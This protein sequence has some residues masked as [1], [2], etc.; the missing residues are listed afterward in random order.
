LFFELGP[1]F[2]R[3]IIWFHGSVSVDWNGIGYG[4]LS[5]WCNDWCFYNYFC[6]LFWNCDWCNLDNWCSHWSSNWGSNWSSDWSSNWGS[7]WSSNWRNRSNYCWDLF[8]DNILI[9]SFIFGNYVFRINDWNS[10]NVINLIC[11]WI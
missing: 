11:L 2:V 10:L 4:F 1:F 8:N 5:L 7:Y 6:Y 9:C 3:H